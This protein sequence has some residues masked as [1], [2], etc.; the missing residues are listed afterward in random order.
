MVAGREPDAM[1]KPATLAALTELVHER[2]GRT[3]VPV[4][5]GTQLDLGAPPEGPFTVVDISR[6]LAGKVQHESDDLTAIVPAA[7]TLGALD[8]ILAARGQRLPI[9]PPL[10]DRATIGGVLATG[11]G[12]PL[13]GRFG[14][15]RDLVIGMTVLRADGELVKA[16]G[17]VVKN[18]TGYDLMRLWCGSLGT[19]GI[20]TQV[21]LRVMPRAETTDLAAPVPSLEAGIA[22]IDRLYRADIR[23][24]IADLISTDRTWRILLR[25]PAATTASTHRVMLDGDLAPDGSL[26]QE[27]RDLGFGEA[28]ALT[29][30][31]TLLAEQIPAACSVLSRFDPQRLVVRPLAGLVRATWT[32][33]CLP[34]LPAVQQTLG[35]LRRQSVAT[36]GSVVVERMPATFRESLNPWGDAP[37]SIELMRRMKQAYDPDGRLNR[38]RFVGGI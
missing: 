30:R 10:A 6:A 9:D 7:T 27:S 37:A 34:G 18:V 32:P 31:L 13:R 20:I 24:E 35:A 25:V 1:V 3:L 5:S 8:T 4:G 38:G 28:D 29:L 2:D 36:G 17:R 16:G 26:Y 22:A 33:D 11:V 14:A 23:P 19:L 12:G 15:P 21:T